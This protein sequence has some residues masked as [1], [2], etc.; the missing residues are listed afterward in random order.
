MKKL[1]SFLCVFAYFASP[2]R[3]AG[4][5]L[6]EIICLMAAM[7][8]FVVPRKLYLPKEYTIFMIYMW[9]VPPIVSSLVGLPGSFFESLLPLCLILTSINL[10]ILIPNVDY[11]LV[12]KYY[13]FLVYIAIGFFILQELSSVLF[14]FKPTL[15]FGFLESYYDGSDMMDFAI[16]RSEMERSSSFF[17][18]P[19]HFV[20]Y[21]IPYVCI[22]ICRC[23][24]NK[25]ISF[26]LIL[27]ISVVIWSKT[28][29][30]L[31]S[32]VIIGLFCFLFCNK[33]NIL[34]KFFI[35]LF[36]AVFLVVAFTYFSDNAIVA[37]ILRR[38][39]EFSITVDAYGQQSG[40][41][42][43]WRGYFIYAAGNIYN[44]IF[45]TAVAAVE[46]VASKVYI[47]GINYEGS[48][49]N[50]IQSL[51]VQGGIVGTLLFGGYIRKLFNLFSISGR[52]IILTMLGLFFMEN[53]LYSPKMFLF[54]IIAYS[55][56]KFEKNKNNY[57]KSIYYS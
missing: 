27:L 18:E 16:S 32:L 47:P 8:Q 55:I 57:E 7:M 39:T 24:Q 10:A 35:S 22:I 46:F 9:L 40:F 4:H 12:I 30:G 19:S 25:K 33:W 11:G 20:Q 51:L 36:I 54:I 44:Q 6:P 52:C 49:M 45:G 13:R 48:Y 23:I 26:E 28:G 17:L 14:G 38:S 53:M 15:Y 42:R 31:F 37:E 1:I 43:I 34:S 56:S 29:T 41:F 3:L 2:Y 21:I 50:G 5:V